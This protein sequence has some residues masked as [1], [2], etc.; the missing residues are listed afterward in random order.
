MQSTQ[1]RRRRRGKSELFDGLITPAE[2]AKELGICVET[3]K[4]WHRAGKGPPKLMLG[5]FPYYS[6][7]TVRDWMQSGACG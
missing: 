5:R 4:R 1:N 2:L 7:S 3:L 6:K